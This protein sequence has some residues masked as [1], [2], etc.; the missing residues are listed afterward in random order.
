MPAQ[1]AFAPFA[2]AACKIDFPDNSFSDEILII[3]SHDFADK[4]MARRSGKTVIPSQQFE[5]GVADTGA[6]QP[7]QRI[8]ARPARFGYLD[9]GRTALFNVDCDHVS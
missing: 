7:N 6:Q 4:L 1:I 9:N 8:A 5:V 2:F 3:R